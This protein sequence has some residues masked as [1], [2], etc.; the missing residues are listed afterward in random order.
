[1]QKIL[2]T[3]DW[4]REAQFALTSAYQKN[5]PIWLLSI[6]SSRGKFHFMLG[7]LIKRKTVATDGML[8]GLEHILGKGVTQV[9]LNK[10][11][12]EYFGTENIAEILE[13]RPDIFERAMKEILGSAGP[14]L[15]RCARAWSIESKKVG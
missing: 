7:E 3:S 9:L 6:Y 1:M 4:I 5:A 11:N 12:Y 15:I 13:A 14:A 10:L 8:L 2:L